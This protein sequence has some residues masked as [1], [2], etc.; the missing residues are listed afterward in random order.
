MG[1]NRLVSKQN[2][3][4]YDSLNCTFYKCAIPYMTS[5]WDITERAEYPPAMKD[6][7]HSICGYTGSKSNYSRN[8][9][10]SFLSQ[11]KFKSLDLKNLFQF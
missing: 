9:F 5:R 8:I 1:P 11:Y 3:T 10:F 7:P 6:I 2:C 4:H